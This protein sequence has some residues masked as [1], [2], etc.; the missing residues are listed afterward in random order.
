[1]VGFQT[2]DPWKNGSSLGQDEVQLSLVAESAPLGVDDHVTG[3][4]VVAIPGSNL[5]IRILVSFT[6]FLIPKHTC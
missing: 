5:V 1:M 6:G 4:P 3:L 2:L